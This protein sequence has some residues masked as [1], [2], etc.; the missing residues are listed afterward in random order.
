M[1]NISEIIKFLAETNTVNFVVMVVILALI[2]KKLDLS[3]AF[4]KGIGNIKSVIEKSDK[5]KAA[6]QANLDKAKALMDGLPNDIKTIEK[7]SAEKIEIFID[8]INNNTQNAIKNID[9][10]VEKTIS[11]EEKKISNLLTEGTSKLTIEKAGENLVNILAQNPE[12]YDKFVEN[13]IK[14]LDKVQL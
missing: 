14:E 9:L 13:S 1:E 7:N 2:V 10:G 8:E 12:L 5:T 4:N 6:A 11:I 3:K